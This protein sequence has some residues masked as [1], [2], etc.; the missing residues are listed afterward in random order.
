MII[1]AVITVIGRDRLPDA[2]LRLL[3]TGMPGLLAG[4]FTSSHDGI[5]FLLVGRAQHLQQDT[6]RLVL[7]S[8]SWYNK[9][10]ELWQSS[11][12]ASRPTRLSSWSSRKPVQAE[13]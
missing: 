13:G 3:G 10:L 11:V 5:C 4:T 8:C 9:T 6:G 12:T 2:Q 1:G 7:P